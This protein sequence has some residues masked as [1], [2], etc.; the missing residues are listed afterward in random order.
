M[1]NHTYFNLNG[2]FSGSVEDHMLWINA[3]YYTPVKSAKAI[4][5]GEL[6]PVEGTPFD[7]TIAK[8]IGRDIKEEFEQLI[9]GQGYDHNFVIDL[10]T[11][12]VEKI[13]SV[14]APKSG[15]QMDVWT[16]CLGVQLYTGNFM[17]GQIGVNGHEF[18]KHGGF[19]LETQYFPNAINEPNFV[20]PITEANVPY[21]SKT[22]YAFSC[23]Q[24][25][26]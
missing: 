20:S 22:V 3:S 15:I 23:P 16:D 21:T 1:T 4:P 26:E 12:G 17:A 6:A 9:F 11:E 10:K 18:I 25:Q 14:Y 7:F 24:N 8:P 19:C 13:A 2:E 5:T